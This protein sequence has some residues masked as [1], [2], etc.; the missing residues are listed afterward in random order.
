MR[1]LPDCI[2]GARRELAG[3]GEVEAS[4]P[5]CSPP[6][7]FFS[8]SSLFYITV[9]FEAKNGLL[10][11]RGADLRHIDIFQ[12]GAVKALKKPSHFSKHSNSK[13]GQNRAESPL[14]AR[15]PL[16]SAWRRNTSVSNGN[17]PR[18]HPERHAST[19]I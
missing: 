6:T 18:P 4:D 10:A 9:N 14:W 5:L 17:I 2:E 3:E 1:L 8:S 19:S 15:K 12:G 16:A 13:K 7:F 11:A